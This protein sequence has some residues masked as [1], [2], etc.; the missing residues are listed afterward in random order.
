VREIVAAFAAERDA[1]N[2]VL[3]ALPDSAFA[4]V[5]NCPPW[6]LD[7]LVIHTAGTVRTADLPDSAAEPCA[8]AADYYRRPE[9]RTENYR[10]SNVDSARAHA[11][12]VL[13]NMTAVQYYDATT[14]DTLTAL[15]ASAGDR[16]VEIPK[17]GAMRMA[18]WALTRL[19]ALTVHGIDAAITL[20]RPPWTT[21]AALRCIRP[22]LE[23]LLGA[24]PPAALGWDD[25]EFLE[26]STGRRPLSAPDRTTLDQLQDRFPLLS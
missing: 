1:A 7:E 11:A 15:R 17:A 16:V 10:Q 22:V 21:Q 5:T 23:S 24:A 9:R 19:I 2:A 3:R 18:D 8:E 20:D 4:V 12:S 25:Q 26:I 6:T 13:S 14:Q